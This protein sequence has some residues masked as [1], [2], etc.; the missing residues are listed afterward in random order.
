MSGSSPT[1]SLTFTMEQLELIPE[2]ENCRDL[3]LGHTYRKFDETDTHDIYKCLHCGHVMES[4]K[5][6]NL[7]T[8][9]RNHQ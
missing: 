7:M 6:P 8:P 2:P 3:G 1:E 4:E 5:K 9:S